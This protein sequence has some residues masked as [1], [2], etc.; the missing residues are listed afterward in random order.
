MKEAFWDYN[1]SKD[2]LFKTARSGSFREKKNLFKKIL[3][4]SSDRVRFIEELFSREDIGKLFESLSI[5][6]YNRYAERT[7]QLAK[8]FILDKR[9]RVTGLEWSKI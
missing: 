7:V 4:N 3:F 5:N 2:D 9:I 8:Y 1:L 6:R